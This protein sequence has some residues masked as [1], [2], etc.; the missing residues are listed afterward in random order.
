MFL[1]DF[2]KRIWPIIKWQITASRTRHI[3]NWKLRRVVNG[4]LIPAYLLRN[5]GLAFSSE[6]IFPQIGITITRRCILNCVDCVALYPHYRLRGEKDIPMDELAPVIGRFLKCVD[7]IH[8]FGLGGGEPFLH[9]DLAAMLDK[10]TAS[11]KVSWVRVYS[12]GMPV[13]KAKTLESLAHPKV[14]VGVSDYGELSKTLDRLRETFADAGVRY[15]I[16]KN[17]WT[18]FGGFEKRNSTG[19]QLVRRFTSCWARECMII[20]NGELHYCYRS[21]HGMD[22]GLI[23]RNPGDY[24]DLMAGTIADVRQNM[25]R[26]LEKKTITA[27]DYCDGCG[28]KVSS[29][30]GEQVRA[31]SGHAGEAAFLGGEPE[32]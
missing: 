19:D 26:F 14:T 17:D 20:I 21:A 25:K 30:R 31:G 12:T 27:C 2:R 3:S 32:A 1:N 4:L 13:P 18:D 11:N 6:F 7:G 24:V 15:R 5:I 23:P 22:L 16:E 9:P 10:V 28:Q 8:A 29:R